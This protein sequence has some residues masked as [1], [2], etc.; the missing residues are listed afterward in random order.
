MVNTVKR[1]EYVKNF[2]SKKLRTA[3]SYIM[4]QLL[5]Y[6][7]TSGTCLSIMI[8]MKVNI[9]I[10]ELRIM[11]MNAFDLLPRI[12]YYLS[13]PPFRSLWYLIIIC[14]IGRKRVLIFPC[15]YLIRVEKWNKI[16][17]AGVI[18][19][20]WLN[21]NKTI[22]TRRKEEIYENTAGSHVAAAA[23]QLPKLRVLHE[24]KRGSGNK[25]KGMGKVTK[26]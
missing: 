8:A 15:T 5:W 13:F 19:I 10:K 12:Q 9:H 14:F 6:F 7:F 16:F 25:L 1:E 23:V 26:T 2:A 21:N 11:H 22:E 18:Y 20:C 3:I 17:K 4:S 24:R